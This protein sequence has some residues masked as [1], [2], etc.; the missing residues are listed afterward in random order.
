MTELYRD[1][2]QRHVLQHRDII[3]IRLQCPRISLKSLNRFE[4]NAPHTYIIIPELNESR[5][6]KTEPSVMTFGYS[7]PPIDVEDHQRC[8]LI[9]GPSAV[10][11]FRVASEV[12]KT[13][14]GTQNLLFCVR[15]TVF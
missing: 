7:E 14:F 6:M 12:H 4:H 2:F 15:G 1:T 9:Q 10:C 11:D 8:R 13:V 3:L 5:L